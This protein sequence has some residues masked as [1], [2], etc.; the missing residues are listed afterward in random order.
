VDVLPLIKINAQNAY[1]AIKSF[2][3]LKAVLNKKF[4]FDPIRKQKKTHNL[5]KSNG[6]IL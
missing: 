6:M 3:F 4:N 1:V 2:V 5:G